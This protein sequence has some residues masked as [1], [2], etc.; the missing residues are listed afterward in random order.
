LNNSSANAKIDGTGQVALT[1]TELKDIAMRLDSKVYW[2]GPLNKYKYVLTV[3]G[4][5]VYFIKY[6]PDGYDPTDLAKK[7]T[8]VATYKVT[9]AF[10]A[11]KSID[12]RED[13]I[14]LLSS[15]GKAIFYSKETATNV[16]AAFPNED[17]QIEV[18]DPS[19]GRA[20]R[21]VNTPGLLKPV[22]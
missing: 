17:L 16:Y 3:N 20:L 6:I 10:E 9:S 15:D 2:I 14:H 12:G 8:T 4:S 7:Y 21:Y 11:I 19:P 1:E 22:A 18:F 13:G 5:G